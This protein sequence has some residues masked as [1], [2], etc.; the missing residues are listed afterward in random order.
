MPPHKLA[1]RV[2]L[3]VRR[4]LRDRLNIGGCV[5]PASPPLTKAPPLPVF[6]P[7]VN[8]LAK[9][10]DGLALTFLGRE[11]VMPGAGV[12]WT[13]PGDGDSD[14][15]WRMNLHYMEYLEAASDADFADVVRDW[16]RANLPARPKAWRDSWNSYALS[17]RVVVLMQQMAARGQSFDDIHRSIA[18]QLYFLEHNLETDLGGNHLIKN[19]KALIWASAY[20]DGRDAERWRRIGLRLLTRELDCQILPDGMHC[21]RSPSYHSQV[22]AD[23]LECRHALGAD[24]LGGKLDCALHRMAA[25]APTWLIPMAASPFLTT[26]ASPW[27]MPRP[28]VWMF[29]SG[30]SVV[31]LK[32]E[33]FLPMQMLAISACAAPQAI[34]SST[35]GASRPTIFLRM[36]MGT[37]F[38][39]NGRSER[40]GFSS[41]RASSNILP[42]KGGGPR[43]VLPATIHCALQAPT[44]LTSSARS[45]AA[46][47]QTWKCA[48]TK[49]AAAAS[50]SK[51][52]TMASATCQAGRG[53]CAAS[54]RT[55]RGFAFSIESRGGPIVPPAS[56]FYCI[57]T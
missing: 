17:I 7:R 1:R 31:D 42:V 27:P 33:S 4:R 8:A 12:D 50:C 44:K 16:I 9:T 47:G 40:K 19:I 35:A 53:M 43:V 24:P 48:A 49:P 26:Q 54:R 30:F 2:E 45:A 56:A 6:A 20:F 38:R 36:A 22:F 23:L 3:D 39:S 32:R 13:R 51:A 14:Q 55:R 15:L 41:T 11:L 18:Q 29:T 5:L 25:A 21:E 37:C 52:L 57:R 28:S 34:S 46:A 10:E